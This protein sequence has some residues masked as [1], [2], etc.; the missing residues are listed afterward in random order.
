MNWMPLTRTYC[1]ESTE[2][3]V[4]FAHTYDATDEVAAERIARKNGWTFVG[5]LVDE[6]EAEEELIAQLEKTLYGPIL[7]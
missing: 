7:H 3:G 5:E 6:I 1:A 2:N 4:W